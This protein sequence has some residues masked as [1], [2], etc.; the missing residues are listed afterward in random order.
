M[1]KNLARLAAHV[2]KRLADTQLDADP[3]AKTTET[4]VPSARLA[5]LVKD[6]KSE[7]V[8]AADRTTALLTWLEGTALPLVDE[9]NEKEEARYDAL[10]AAAKVS[11][12]CLRVLTILR[13]RL[14]TFVYFN[15]YFRVRPMIHLEHLADR[16]ETKLLDDDEYDFGNSCLLKLL[17]FSARKLS[18]LGKAATPPP[19]NPAALKAY[20][21]Q[22]GGRTYNLNAASVKLTDHIRQAWQPDAKKG[23]ASALATRAD[24]QYLKVV[25]QD[26]LG[27][28]V[29]L[30]QRSEGFQWLGA[31]QK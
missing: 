31:V 18:E 3:E 27:V 23:E 9:D 5:V 26:E 6:W 24:Q 20:R 13:E 12:K 15:N 10:L 29:E 1:T 11:E 4:A 19:G 2:D 21:D 25:V 7:T 22:L 17:G 14:P 30:D 8:L 16:L 28:E